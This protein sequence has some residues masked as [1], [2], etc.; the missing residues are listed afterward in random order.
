MATGSTR[1]PSAACSQPRCSAW[2]LRGS[3]AT[4]AARGLLRPRALAVFSVGLLVAG[5]ANGMVAIAAGRVLQ[6]LGSGM[7]GVALY[8]GVGQIVPKPLHPR[9]FALFAAA[10]VVPGP[11]GPPIAA[12]LVEW[13]GWRSVFLVVA[14]IVPVAAALL[15]PSLRVSPEKQAPPR[16]HSALVWAA[17]AAAGALLLNAAGSAASLAGTLA[18]GAAGALV[19]LMAARPLLPRGSLAAAPGLPSVIALRGLLAAGFGTAEAFVPLYL[20]RAHDWSLAQAGVALSVGAVCWSAG[21]AVQARLKAERTRQRGL[22]AGLA[23]VAA[24]TAIVT[25][26]ALLPVPAAVLVAGWAVAG[27]GIGLSFPMLSVLTLQLSPAEEQGRNASALQLADALTS[28][29]ALALAG[30][31]FAHGGGFVAVMAVAVA[32]PSLAALLSRRL[33]PT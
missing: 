30:A 26:P 10:W 29:A 8:V 27:F 17:L 16:T 33:R 21:S 13:F 18:M 23:L 24:G 15:L 5:L 4:G 3:G 14:L 6:G 32:L 28:S 9:L 1:W 22:S 31:L 25:L 2:W 19:A 7:L 11:V 12:L 20:N